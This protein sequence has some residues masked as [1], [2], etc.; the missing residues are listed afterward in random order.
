MR[1]VCTSRPACRSLW[2]K[3]EWKP[4]ANH[5]NKCEVIIPKHKKLCTSC[6]KPKFYICILC[7]KR[8]ETK[9]AVSYFCLACWGKVRTK[10]EISDLVLKNRQ[11]EMMIS[12]YEK[13]MKAANKLNDELQEKNKDY[14]ERI[15]YLEYLNEKSHSQSTPRIDKLY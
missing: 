14:R 5:C 9:S 4:P 11:Y 7:G 6:K 12:T 2:Q 8:I 3:K 13:M 15:K 1:C 10:K